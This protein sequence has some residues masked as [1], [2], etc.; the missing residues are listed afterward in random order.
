MSTDGLRR[1]A[2]LSEIAHKIKNLRDHLRHQPPDF[3]LTGG[4]D[5]ALAAVLDGLVVRNIL[6]QTDSTY[7]I[8]E[9]DIAAFYANSVRQF[10]AADAVA[11]IPELA[12][13]KRSAKT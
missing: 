11:S 6:S 10:L 5:T 8:V 2:T 9:T 13:E 4:D 7:R 1:T 12:T 3:G